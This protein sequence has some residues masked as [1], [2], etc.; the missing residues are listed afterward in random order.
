MTWLCPKCNSDDLSVDITITATARLIQ[1]DDGN[2]Q[3]DIDGGD[4]V[5]DGSSRMIC[6]A[7]GHEGTAGGFEVPDED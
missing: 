1:E 5:W 4:H 3:T 2:F 6:N 7:C